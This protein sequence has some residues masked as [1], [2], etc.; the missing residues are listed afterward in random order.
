MVF[1]MT[2]CISFWKN[3]F[4]KSN[5]E[6]GIFINIVFYIILFKLVF[7]ITKSTKKHRYHPSVNSYVKK[8]IEI[9]IKY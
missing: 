6:I 4:I 3:G 2:S 5:I 9:F 8:A 1:R 7:I